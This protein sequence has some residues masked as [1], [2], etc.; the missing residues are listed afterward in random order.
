MRHILEKAILVAVVAGLSGCSAGAGLL[1]TKA[2]VPVATNVP[3]G[4]A[5]ALPPD[6][7]LTAPTQT[8]DAYQSNGVVAQASAPVS[9]KPSKMK[10]A[11]A[12]PGTLY[13]GAA[14]AA[15]APPADVFAQ[16]GISKV[17]P[18]GTAKSIPKMNEELRA[19]I[20]KKKRETN[21]SYGTI[22]NIGAIF[23]DQ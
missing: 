16:Y 10:M 2:G 21:P 14:P 12:E 5:L 6:L 8:T 18:D 1:D 7:Q 11:S 9:S 4:N 23:Q 13:G 19:A 15:P 20:I 3:V 17:N 22:G